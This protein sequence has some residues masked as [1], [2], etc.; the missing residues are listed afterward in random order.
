MTRAPPPFLLSIDRET[1]LAVDLYSRKEDSQILNG[2]GNRK[3]STS[4]PFR[5]TAV[6]Y[7]VLGRFWFVRTR[8][9]TRYDLV[10]SL[11]LSYYSKRRNPRSFHEDFDRIL[12]F[13]YAFISLNFQNDPSH[14]RYWKLFFFLLRFLIP[15]MKRKHRYA[16]TACIDLLAIFLPR[17]PLF[18]SFV[19]LLDPLTKSSLRINSMKLKPLFVHLAFSSLKKITRRF[20]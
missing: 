4:L 19:A 10:I 2:E 8:S 7:S 15:G 6:G 1:L 9:L 18:F 3:F 11:S 17:I 12:H 5:A 16:N 14:F 20:V 13:Y